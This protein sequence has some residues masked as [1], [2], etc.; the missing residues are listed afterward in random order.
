MGWR[1]FKIP[2]WVKFYFLTLHR[3]FKLSYLH[4]FKT[5]DL[6]Q[7][8]VYSFTGF[9]S[10]TPATNQF[11]LLQLFIFQSSQI[12][13]LLRIPTPTQLLDE[14]GA[15]NGFLLQLFPVLK[16]TRLQ[17]AFLL[18][19]HSFNSMD[20]SSS[21]VMIVFT[22]ISQ[23]STEIPLFFHRFIPRLSELIHPK[24]AFTNSS[25]NMQDFKI[26]ELLKY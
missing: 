14:V 5:L 2:C 22:V 6:R 26:L 17:S 11:S 19:F 10:M 23:F 16:K 12:V 18:K 8:L 13:P 20:T 25:G 9:V 24:G 7:G 15:S 3:N 1:P 4:V 21:A